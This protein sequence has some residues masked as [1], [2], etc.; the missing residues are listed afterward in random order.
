MTESLRE[1]CIEAG[2]KAAAIEY[3]ALEG[4][5]WLDDA[6]ELAEEFEPVAIGVLDAVLD[7]LEESADE[8]PA[9]VTQNVW[10]CPNCGTDHG[11]TGCGEPLPVLWRAFTIDE[12]LSVLRGNSE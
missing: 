9:T 2:T 1:R 5:E 3:Y 10:R 4:D 6:V 12:L 11:E 8:L 7:V